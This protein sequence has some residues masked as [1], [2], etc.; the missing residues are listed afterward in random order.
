MTCLKWSSR[1]AT[2]IDVKWNNFLEAI[3]DAEFQPFLLFFWD[4][5]ACHSLSELKTQNLCLQ[6]LKL[7]C[8]I[9]EAI[10]VARYDVFSY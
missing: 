5:A 9:V 7:P 1:Q 3:N 10:W 4:P 6:K 8:D 2:A